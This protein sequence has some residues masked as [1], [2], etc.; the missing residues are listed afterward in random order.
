MKQNTKGILFVTVILLVVLML[1]ISACGSSTVTPT[2]SSPS[3]PSGSSG[4]SVAG[5]SSSASGTCYVGTWKMGDFSVYIQSLKSSMETGGAKV[6]IDTQA[7]TGTDQFVFNSDGSASYTATNFE[8]KFM[9][10]R[11]ANGKTVSIP[12][13]IDENGTSTSTFTVS[14]DQLSFTKQDAS[15][16]KATLNAMGT[17]TTMDTSLLGKPGTV[18]VYTFTCPDANT[19]TL[20][21]VSTKT[22]ALGAFT[23]IR[24]N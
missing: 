14:G 22:S 3:S 9:I 6:T 23:L 15:G 10:N 2:A 7:Y 4:T 1:V 12:V 18:S 24:I 11:T 16:L 21:V 17:T 20:Q 8:Q 5:S 13:A 19:L